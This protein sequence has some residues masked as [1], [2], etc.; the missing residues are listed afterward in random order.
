LSALRELYES[1]N[2]NPSSLWSVSRPERANQRKEDL[3]PAAGL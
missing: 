1:E 2:R 3:Q